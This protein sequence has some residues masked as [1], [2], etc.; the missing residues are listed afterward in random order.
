MK[1][2]FPDKLAPLF[3]P[4]PYK[5]VYGGRGKGASWGFARAALILG[6]HRPLFIVCGREVQKSI[7]DSVKLLLEN[8]IEELGFGEHKTDDGRIIPAFYKSLDVEVRG[9]NGTR[10]SFVGLNDMQSIK[11]ME[12]IDV[13]WLTEAQ[14]VHKAKWTVLLP[15]VRGDPPKGPFQQG[16]EVWVDFNP[17][18][19]SDDTYQ[20]WV[21]DPPRDTIAIEM[22]FRDNPFFPDIL[23]RQ[24]EEMRDKDRDEYLTVWEGKTRKVLAGAIFAREIEKGVVDGRIGPNIQYVRGRGVYASFDLGDA[25]TTAMWVWQQVGNEHHAIDFVEEVGQDITYFLQYLQDQKYLVK[26]IILPHDAAQSHQSARK[27]R[28]NTI[29]KQAR[30]A[31]EQPGIVEVVPITSIPIRINAA[32]SLFPRICINDVKCS[33]GMMSLQHYQF[34]VDPKTKERT[35]TP[36]HNWASNGASSFCEYAV[37]LHEGRRKQRERDTGNAERDSA[38]RDAGSQGWMV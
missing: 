2:R 6:S 29:E 19:T 3:T 18:L 4:A 7:K 14:R 38:F 5:I 11:S 22:N 27:L 26:K 21:V 37:Q 16:S 30:N 12:G 17:E 35:R 10:I 28:H 20:M 15:T 13:F 1:V 34:G 33:Q 23:R 9:A 36:L 25:D 31:Y 32:R 24:M 8:Q